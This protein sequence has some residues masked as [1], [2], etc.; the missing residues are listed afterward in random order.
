MGPMGPCHSGPAN[1]NVRDT[2]RRLPRCRPGG[3]PRS[4]A[5]QRA[6]LAGDL[7]VLAGGHHERAHARRGPADLPV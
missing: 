7:Q 1:V 5:E 2:I 4:L 6:H 3:A